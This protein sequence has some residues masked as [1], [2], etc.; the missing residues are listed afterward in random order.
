[1]LLSF[2]QEAQHVLLGD[3]ATLTGTANLA[4]IEV[5]LGQ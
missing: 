4:G 2:G 5:V 3:T 1:L